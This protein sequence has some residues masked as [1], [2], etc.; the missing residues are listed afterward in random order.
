MILHFLGVP[1]S[2]V[3]ARKPSFLLQIA[4]PW[5]PGMRNLKR[6]VCAFPRFVFS[7]NR[8]TRIRYVSGVAFRENTILRF[9]MEIIRFRA[10]TES[11]GTSRKSQI[12]D[13]PFEKMAPF[14]K[15]RSGRS[16]SLKLNSFYQKNDIWFLTFWRRRGIQFSHETLLFTFQIAKRMIPWKA[17]PET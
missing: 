11:H 4:K 17:E 2:A 12:V 7:R 1:R 3:F 9:G 5:F 8:E 10:E 15:R 6:S 16:A 13:H 14:S